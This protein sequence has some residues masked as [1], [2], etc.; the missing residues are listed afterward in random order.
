MPEKNREKLVHYASIA[1]RISLGVIFLWFG[2]LK[3]MNASPVGPLLEA[4]YP[5]FAT[6]YGLMALG[7]FEV[8][9]GLCLTFNVFPVLANLALVLHLCGTLTVFF[10]A[11]ELMFNPHFPFLTMTGEF[12]VKNI[13]LIAAGFLVGAQAY[14]HRLYHTD[15]RM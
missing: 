2:V 4:T 7:A 1:L 5:L 11:P 3:V 10:I 13:A 6:T 8:V 9:V 12:V 14:F 15:A